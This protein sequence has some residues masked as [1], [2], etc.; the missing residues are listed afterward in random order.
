[1]I[2]TSLREFTSLLPRL[3]VD[4]AQLSN[5]KHFAN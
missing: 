4:V 3:S 2:N 5:R 1:M